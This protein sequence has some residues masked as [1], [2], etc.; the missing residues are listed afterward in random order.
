MNRK[1]FSPL[2]VIGIIA[3]IVIVGLVGYFIWHNNSSV[4]QP[5]NP[6]CCKITAAATSTP[7]AADVSNWQMYTNQQYGFSFKYPQGWNVQTDVSNSMELTLTLSQS[8]AT[9]ANDNIEINVASGTISSGLASIQSQEIISNV[10]QQTFSLITSTVFSDSSGF[11]Y[12]YIGHDD[13]L[14]DFGGLASEPSE[15]FIPE[16]LSTLQF[17]QPSA[18]STSAVD[19]SN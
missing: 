8:G 18:S 17:I 12:F 3:V 7:S 4:S 13:L 11:S 5:Q 19:I 2:I 15:N 10:H 16:I 1:G 14:F 9:S 6:P